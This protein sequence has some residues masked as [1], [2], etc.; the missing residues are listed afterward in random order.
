MTVLGSLF[1][2]AI[3]ALASPFAGAWSAVQTFGHAVPSV[4]LELASADRITATAGSETVSTVFSSAGT[5]SFKFHDGSALALRRLHDGTIIGQW[6]QPMT[7]TFGERFVSP[8][9]FSRHG[10]ASFVGSVNAVPDV[11]HFF[12]VVTQ[13]ADGGLTAFLRNPEINAGARIGVRTFTADGASVRLTAPDKPPIAGTY[14]AK[15]QTL[16]LT[17][18]GFP[19][20]FEFRK[21]DPAKTPGFTPLQGR[22]AYAY[23]APERTSDGWETASLSDVGL[24]PAKVGAFIDA[25]AQAPVTSPAA[26]YIH[27]VAIARHG[28]L[29]LDTYFYGYDASTLHDVRSA[30]KS[31]TTLMVGDAMRSD[32]ALHADST[33]RSVLPQ[34]AS[35]L[36]G[37]PRKKTITVADLMTMSS[38]LAC[39][40]ND[41]QSPGNEDTMEQQTAQPD[42][43][44]FALDLP[45]VTDPGTKAVYCSAGINLLGAVI[46]KATNAWLPD[47]FYDRFAA[48]MQFGAYALPLTPPPL[49]TAYMAGGGRFA[50]R[51]FLKFGQLILDRGMWNGRR[52]VDASW[53][54]ALTTPRA[55]LN[56]PGDYG[57][58]WH[59]STFN[60]GGISYPAMNAGGNGGQLL[61]VIPKLDMAVMITAGN[62][63]Q[64]GVWRNFQTEPFVDYLIPAATSH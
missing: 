8:V 9:V 34:Y 51:D 37:D 39:D 24:D 6:M 10:P 47:E 2:S 5:A 64:Y 28:K 32:P 12:L 56:A 36:N 31:V 26:P 25:L 52:I 43:Y 60:V 45:V 17:I 19:S 15:A 38:G 58:G 22:A 61:F 3:L 42:W 50:P 33:L 23:A 63:G 21:V 53:I 11:A 27:S 40:D 54:D 4:S 14:D 62:Y 16:Q 48:P 49:S 55:A 20:A 1:T 59:L 29:V 44:K 57:Y 30:G 18:D 7:T 35:D 13:N 46:A 41:D